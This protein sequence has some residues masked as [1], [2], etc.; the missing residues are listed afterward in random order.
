MEP[1]ESLIP[2]NDSAVNGTMGSNKKDIEALEV[3]FS[4]K[5]PEKGQ[6]KNLAH[7]FENIDPTKN[8][9]DTVNKINQSNL[10]ISQNE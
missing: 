7:M 10:D 8:L 5:K 2:L 6:M 1:N 4:S 9:E 3:M